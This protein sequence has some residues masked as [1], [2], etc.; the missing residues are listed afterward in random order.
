M[1]LQGPQTP[2]GS[3]VGEL[4]VPFGPMQFRALG[5]NAGAGRLGGSPRSGEKIPAGD[6]A[7]LIEFRRVVVTCSWPTT[8]SKVWGRYLR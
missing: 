4:N 2:H 6:A 8:S 1:D 7:L 3:G 5:E